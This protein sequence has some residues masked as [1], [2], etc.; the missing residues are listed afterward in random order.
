VNKV[1]KALCATMIV[2]LFAGSA[3]AATEP[4][5][6]NINKFISNFSAPAGEDYLSSFYEAYI[7]EFPSG[8]CDL[9][10][11][12][13]STY[14]PDTTNPQGYNS[15]YVNKCGKVVAPGCNEDL[16]KKYKGCNNTTPVNIIPENTTP[17]A[18]INTTPVA[19]VNTTPVINDTTPVEYIS[20][21]NVNSGNTTV[22]IIETIE[23]YIPPNPAELV[24]T[25]T[26]N[27]IS[28]PRT[29]RDDARYVHA[30]CTKIV[31]TAKNTSAPGVGVLNESIG[32]QVNNTSSKID[33]AVRNFEK[34][35]DKSPE[36][37]RKLLNYIFG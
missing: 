31:D 37:L 10:T 21:E 8:D 14:Y 6:E 34:S 30:V 29:M 11:N 20:K 27:N 25:N 5:Y 23:P 36:Y 12:Y 1:V 3:T 9:W 4:T 13:V 26:S 18:P 16:V 19:P 2:L 15:I 22:E 32:T 28:A 35:E 24:Q 17:V 7:Q 33:A